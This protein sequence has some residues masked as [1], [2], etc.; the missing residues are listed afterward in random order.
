MD[1]SA[2]FVPGASLFEPPL[3]I[4]RCEV[5][6]ALRTSLSLLLPIQLQYLSQQGALV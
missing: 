2:R 1:R 5:V 6:A 4:F 3:I